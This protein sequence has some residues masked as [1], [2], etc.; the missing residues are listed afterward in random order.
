MAR[1]LVL[2]DDETML[3]MY[4]A[5]LK[6]LGHEPVTKL[7]LESGPETVREVAAE[8]LVV[9]LQRPDDDHYGLRIIEELRAQPEWQAFPIVL[10]TGA[11]EE[12]VPVLPKLDSLRVP[13]LR[14][15]FKIEDLSTTLETV[16][17]EATPGP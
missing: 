13:I 8:A 12:L 15:P 9:D 7:V 14:K 17:T 3:D 6:E 10:C 16:I 2:N 5:A 11:V 4:A 1:V